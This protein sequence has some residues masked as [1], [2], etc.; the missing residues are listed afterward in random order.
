MISSELRDVLDC[1]VLGITQPSVIAARC[2]LSLK[3]TKKLIQQAMDAGY[4]KYS[5]TS[6]GRE[7]PIDHIL[8]ESQKEALIA[9]YRRRYDGFL[10]RQE[11]FLHL[12]TILQTLG[13]IGLTGNLTKR[14]LNT[15]QSLIEEPYDLL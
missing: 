12:W 6:K 14:G 7:L 3:T 9:I 10:D 8:T 15:V 5:L 2:G 1:I 11:F 4:I 13:Y